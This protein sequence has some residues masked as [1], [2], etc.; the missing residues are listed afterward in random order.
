MAHL[1]KLA[2]RLVPPLSSAGG[3]ALKQREFD[4]VIVGAGS[5]GCVLANEL[6][7]DGSKEVLVVEAGGWDWNPLIHI[8]AGVY[9]VFK[10]PSLNWNLQTEPE[11]GC[12]GRRV[13]LPRGKVVGGSSSINAMVYMRG[14]PLDYDGWAER[15]G[16]GDE[17]RWDRCLPYFKRCESS[18]RGASEHRGGQG[19]LEVTKGAMDNPLYEALIEAGAQSGQGVSDDLN[20]Y[21]PEGVARLDRTATRDG[22]RCSA[23]EAH[24]VPALERPNVTLVTN[25]LV[26]RLDLEG[27]GGGGGGG[28]SSSSSSSSGGGRAKARGI[29]LRQAGG[30]TVTV[31]ARESVILSAGSIK[32]PQ[33]MMLSG[34]GPRE[35][36]EEHGIQCVRDMPGVGSNLQDH[37]CINTA[38]TCTAPGMA[39]DYLAQ[40]HHKLA[41]GAQW[42]L[43]GSGVCASN[44]WEAGGL[45]YSGGAAGKAAAEATGG[46]GGGSGGGSSSSSS[47]QYGKHDYPN[48]QYHF[49]PVY[50]EYRGKGESGG[51]LDLIAGFQVQVDQLRPKSRGAVRL[52]SADPAAD[53]ATT[54]NYMTD[55]QGQDLNELVGGYRA[56]QELLLQPAFDAFRGDLRLPKAPGPQTDAEIGAFVR[57]TSGTDYHPCGTAKMGAETSTDDGVVVNEHFQ[58]RGVDGLHVVDAS[59]MPSIVSGNLNA[60]VQMLAMRA[61][62][63]IRG[64]DQMAPERPRYHFEEE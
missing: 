53:P 24:L 18:D 36:L 40:P 56:A 47:Y 25:H 61:A 10:D 34:L 19:R 12:D 35:H 8:P 20:G 32:T 33:L 9:S 57:S 44:V 29:H 50:A 39:L 54:F 59:V 1:L 51:G 60:P 2:R 17:W 28:S 52:R 31:R 45:V 26:E 37:A 3:G 58:V 27:G 49:A 41:V 55:A 64:V 46:G 23:A 22:R 48:L 4:Y 7:A 21:K 11:P 5:A 15:D 42:L 38:F 6:S 30:G 62:D 43:D 14:H 13:E 16:L 63:F